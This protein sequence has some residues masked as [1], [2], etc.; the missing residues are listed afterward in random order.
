MQKTS[1]GNSVGGGGAYFGIG[2]EF[3]YGERAGKAPGHFETFAL[4]SKSVAMRDAFARSAT[5]LQ[6]DYGE[7]LRIVRALRAGK[8]PGAGSVVKG[9]SAKGVLAT[10]RV[11]ANQRLTP[12]DS[13]DAVLLFRLVKD[14]FGVGQL[15]PQRRLR[16][17]RGTRPRGAARRGRAACSGRPSCPGGIPMQASSWSSTPVHKRGLDSAGEPRPL[18]GALNSVYAAEELAPIA[19]REPFAAPCWIR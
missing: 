1:T 19:F 18:G 9:W 15:G 7:M 10:A 13:G 4:R 16:V 3:E 12:S 11:V 14:V 17:R 5:N 8:A 6:F 2:T